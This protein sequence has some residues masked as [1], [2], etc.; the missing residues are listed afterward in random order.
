M[1]DSLEMEHM[2]E[3]EPRPEDMR[4]D[5]AGEALGKERVRS[6]MLEN[7]MLDALEVLNGPKHP[8][9]EKVD[10][11]K[12]ILSTALDMDIAGVSSREA[13]AMIRLARSGKIAHRDMRKHAG[14]GPT[15]V[16]PGRRRNVANP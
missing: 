10:A 7:G 5:Y 3:V 2:G 14:Q 16:K 15:Q 12:W 8:D 1:L 6:G 13:L 4:R 11:A 9:S